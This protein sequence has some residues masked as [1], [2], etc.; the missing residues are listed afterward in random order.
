[1]RFASA[2]VTPLAVEPPTAS[3]YQVAVTVG[4]LFA[5]CP[6][7]D[8]T[9][10][11]LRWRLRRNPNQLD[12]VTME[13][14]PIDYVGVIPSQTAGD[15]IRYRVDL[16][17]AVGATQSFPENPA[18]PMYEMFVGEVAEIY[19]ADFE[20]DPF[21][22]GW[23][24]GLLSASYTGQVDD[25]DWGAP[26]G[27]ERNGDPTE[28]FSGDHVIGN[29]LAQDSHDGVY[30]PKAVSYADSPLVDVSEANDPRLQ[31]QRWLQV[32]DGY[33]DVARIYVNGE[34][35]WESFGSPSEPAT[36]HHTDREWRF[37]DI[38]LSPY[39][40]ADGT[41]QIRFEIEADGN[42]VQRG[43]WTLDDVCIVDYLGA[44]PGTPAC[45]NGSLEAG[46]QCDDGNTLPGDG[47]GS[48]C[49]V[50]AEPEVEP[51]PA[52]PSDD[53]GCGCRLEG[54]T[55]EGRWSWLWL[56]VAAALARR[57]LGRS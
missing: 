1:L 30:A 37:Q 20:T 23:T 7:D 44:V 25:W 8:I 9:S 3:G 35:V 17:V 19:C 24:H 40:A 32:E 29:D 26:M 39:V 36:T 22:D 10:A 15:V 11:K 46:E 27:T 31:I 38:D 14:G 53:G 55:S 34:P 54:Q 43:G 5:Q 49:M 18:D 47:C 12:T 4:G 21:L 13:G 33:F 6:G 45:G 57:R 2:E 41:V 51:P 16:G 42:G 52:P 50:E 48:F 56:V 28:A